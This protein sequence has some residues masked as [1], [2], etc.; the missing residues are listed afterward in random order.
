M[1]ARLLP[2]PSLISALATCGT[3]SARLPARHGARRSSLKRA[4]PTGA[5]LPRFLIGYSACA[6]TLA[7]F[8][9]AGVDAWTCDLL[10]SRG[11]PDRHIQA[12]VRE[13]A[14]CGHWD[15]A[16]FHPM[17]THL[18]VSAAW[19][20]NDP[21]FERWPG[22]G[23]HQRV[24][25]G[26]LTGAA[27][28]AQRELELANFRWLLAL[29]YPKAIE[30]P[31][32]SFVSDAI[33][34]PDQT[35]QPHQFGDDASKRTGLWLDRLPRL[36]PTGHAPARSGSGERDLLGDPL[37]RRWGNQ[38]DSGQN[39]LSERADRWLER[40]ATFPGIAAAMGAQW[41]GYITRACR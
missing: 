1:G 14:E 36:R 9:A 41:G 29:P 12:D 18:T 37:V 19:A 3:R 30:N 38:T 22:V 21:D 25:P 23:Y 27:R 8:E 24:K 34:P 7:A 17:C 31:A 11:R 15:A 39:R 16:L 4:L 26:T 10:P 40:S 2:P 20:F 28:R 13:V 35:I 5:D 6:L 32:P 33:R